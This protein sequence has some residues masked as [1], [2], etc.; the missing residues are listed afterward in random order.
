MGQRHTLTDDAL[1]VVS[2]PCGSHGTAATGDVSVARRDVSVARRDVTRYLRAPRATMACRE[3]TWLSRLAFFCS[4]VSTLFLKSVF[5]DIRISTFLS[6]W[7]MYS[8]FLRLLSCA[9]IWKNNSI[10]ISCCVR[11]KALKHLSSGGTI[12]YLI[13]NFPPDLLQ[14]FLLCLGER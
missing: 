11:K 10:F 12:M 8:F 3:A 13:L 7:S 4:R 14:W 2:Q 1:W 5:S 6:S 9:E